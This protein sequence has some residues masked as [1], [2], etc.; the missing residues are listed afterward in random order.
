MSGFGRWRLNTLMKKL[1]VISHGFPPYYGGAE[2]AAYYLAREAVADGYSVTVLTS[3]IGG[4][5]PKDEIVED[6][7]IRRV[8]TRKKRW[9]RHSIPELLSFI[10]TAKREVI[11]L[12]DDERPDYVL[13]NCAI[14]AGYIAFYAHRRRSL[15]YTVILQGSDVPGYKNSRFALVYPFVTPVM[16]RIWR[17]ASH[18][19]AVSPD[20]R[21]LALNAWPP[22][23]VAVIENGVDTKFFHPRTSSAV[24]KTSPLRVAVTAQLIERKGLQH[25]ISALAG[26]SGEKR[27]GFKIDIYG[28][29]PF[30]SF[31]RRAIDDNDISGSVSL[32]GLVERATLAE[33]L[34]AADVFVLPSLQE[35]RSL[36]MLEAMASGL[37]VIVT[38]AA[39]SGIAEH[40]VNALV[41]PPADPGSLKKALLSLATDPALRRTLGQAARKSAEEHAWS[42][43]WQQHAG[44]IEG[45]AGV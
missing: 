10:R 33:N 20:L 25:L 31:L 1:L 7:H 34:A 40:G 45:T 28:Q 35:G 44:L 18:V 38:T 15:P 42:R 6:L 23:K 41:V 32:P 43:I 12:I 9:T 14:P 3:D 24:D 26:M 30:E 21:D 37:P 27:A 13:A 29:G 22:G 8:P 36:A 19:A 4:R 11:R 16:R 5:L 17:S 2:H 39:G